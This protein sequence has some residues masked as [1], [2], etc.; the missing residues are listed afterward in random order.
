MKAQER[1]RMEAS[2]RRRDLSENRQWVIRGLEEPAWQEWGWGTKP[3]G[4]MIRPGHMQSQW[5]PLNRTLCPSGTTGSQGRYKT[6]PCPVAWKIPPPSNT[7][8]EKSETPFWALLK[9]TVNK[10]NKKRRK[11]IAQALKFPRGL[12]G[13]GCPCQGVCLSFQFLVR[14][15]GEK[16]CFWSLINSLLLGSGSDPM[17]FS[18]CVNTLWS[19]FC[20]SWS[21]FHK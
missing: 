17:G 16:V 5:R 13:A 21:M 12:G 20:P 8:A 10:G 7:A 19:N 14:R 9:V 18:L 11:Q 1:K 6:K 4:V 15:A 2:C 3:Q